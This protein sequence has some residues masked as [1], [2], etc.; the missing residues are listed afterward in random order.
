MFWKRSVR[1]PGHIPTDPSLTDRT[2]DLGDGQ[3]TFMND[4]LA[5]DAGSGPIQTV[6][7]GVNDTT[8][9]GGRVRMRIEIADDSTDS[10]GVGIMRLD[11]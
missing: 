2:E 6:R 11:F 9:L 1:L 8:G 10:K 4:E 7:S 5:V 3:N